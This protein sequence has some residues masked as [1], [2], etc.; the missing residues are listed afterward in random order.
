MSE[1]RLGQRV[2]TNTGDG[3]GEIVEIEDDLDYGITVVL[4]NGELLGFEDYELEA[5]DE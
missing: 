1:F 2:N 5:I 3:P 4:D